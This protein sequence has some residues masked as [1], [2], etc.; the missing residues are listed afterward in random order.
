MVPAGKP[1]LRTDGDGRESSP[2]YGQRLHRARL[3]L[4][5]ALAPVVMLFVAFASAYLVRR[6][7]GAYDGDRGVYTQDWH[8]IPLPL[9][10]LLLNTVALALS[11]VTAE[12]ARRQLARR[13]ILAPVA[14]IPGISLGQERNPPWLLLTVILGGAFLTGQFLVWRQ[15]A[16][17]GFYVTGHPGSSFVY[18][19]TMLHAVHVG[20]GMLVLQWALGMSVFHRSLES[21][22]IVVDI[23]A[24]YW[25]FMGALWV[26]IFAVL[27][28]V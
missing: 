25:H 24:W 27:L 14:E 6:I 7:L 5:I 20:A 11:S 22:R 2:D 17:Q 16:A 10:Q 21:R 26:L 1:G 19:L 4:G 28:L 8:S 18:L 23:A 13:V 12:L 9:V 15:L 3:G